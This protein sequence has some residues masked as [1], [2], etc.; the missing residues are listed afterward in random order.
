MYLTREP[1]DRGRVIHNPLGS[2]YV[3]LLAS[4]WNIV[5]VN[6]AMGCGYKNNAE[7]GTVHMMLRS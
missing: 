6:S 2:R 7:Y 5:E 3:L 1:K 4:L